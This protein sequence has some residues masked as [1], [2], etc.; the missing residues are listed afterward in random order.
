MIIFERERLLVRH[1]RDDDFDQLYALC[2]DP[3]IIRYMGNRQ[4]IS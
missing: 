3:E 2:R 4:P 1:L